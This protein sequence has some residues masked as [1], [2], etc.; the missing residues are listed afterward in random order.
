MADS[1]RVSLLVRMPAPLKRALAREVA[2]RGG[3][4]NDVAVSIL[5]ERFGVRFDPSGRRG[6]STPGASG[7]V[8]LR[9]PPELKTALRG[10]ADSSASTTNQLVVNTLTEE[11]RGRE[12]MAQTNGKTNG[13]G[14]S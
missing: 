14:R 10:E 4:M 9:V 2:R 7:A 13:R 1:R 11:L 12:P 8:L 5:A 6:G 3:T